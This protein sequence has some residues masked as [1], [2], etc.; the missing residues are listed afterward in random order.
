MTCQAH[1]VLVKMGQMYGPFLFLNFRCPGAQG[2]LLETPPRWHETILSHSNEVGS[3]ARPS[4]SDRDSPAGCFTWDTLLTKKPPTFPASTC[5]IIWPFY[6]SHLRALGEV[7]LLACDNI[8]NIVA[9]QR[10][11]VSN[12]PLGQRQDTGP[13]IIWSPF[14]L[15]QGKP[16]TSQYI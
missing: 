6:L 1:L 16:G 15:R 7:V 8:Y 4:I 14:L 13:G 9:C 11:G 10:D 5:T 3:L 2:G 12:K